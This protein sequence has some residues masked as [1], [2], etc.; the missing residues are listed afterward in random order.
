[1]AARSKQLA[2]LRAVGATQGLVVR[3]VVAEAIVLGIIGSAM[4]LVLGVHIAGD[5]MSLVDRMWGLPLRLTMPWGL[6]ATA[7]GLTIGLCVL[8]GVLPARRA[9]R[10]NIVDALRVT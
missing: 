5:L 8:A 2:V 3:L 9:A 7:V 1:V 4:G 10:T 6:V